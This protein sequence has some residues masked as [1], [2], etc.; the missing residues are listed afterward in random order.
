[1]APNGI[2]VTVH[3]PYEMKRQDSF[4]LAQSGLMD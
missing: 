2:I 4:L 1:M 3:G